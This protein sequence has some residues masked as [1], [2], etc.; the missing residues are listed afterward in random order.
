[1]RME[2]TITVFASSVR[3]NLGCSLGLCVSCFTATSIQKPLH[4]AC[5]QISD[6]CNS[7]PCLIG[8]GAMHTTSMVEPA[9]SQ[10]VHGVDTEIQS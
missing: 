2:S 9:A 6:Q 1:M 4:N 5:T 8:A 7:I 3:V 10:H